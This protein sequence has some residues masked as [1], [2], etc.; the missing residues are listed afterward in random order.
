MSRPQTAETV[1]GSSPR[2]TSSAQWNEKRR[3]ESKDVM[4][5]VTRC[6]MGKEWPP[7]DAKEHGCDEAR[8]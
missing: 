2:A 4:V 3:I 1:P 7:M 5:S 6:F 8:I